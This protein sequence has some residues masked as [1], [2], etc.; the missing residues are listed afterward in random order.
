MRDI[1]DKVADKIR[2]H[3]VKDTSVNTLAKAA[4]YSIELQ[5]VFESKQ[6]NPVVKKTITLSRR[7]TKKSTICDI[8]TAATTIVLRI[9]AEDAGR[10][11]ALGANA[12][13]ARQTNADVA[14]I[15]PRTALSLEIEARL[16]VLLVT[17]PIIALAI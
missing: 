13:V 6:I 2:S 10:A 4:Q 15:S 16:C 9:H 7:S 17:A 11:A 12:A 8:S 5:S 14:V 3:G 1:Y